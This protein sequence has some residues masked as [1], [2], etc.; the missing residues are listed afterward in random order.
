MYCI[1]AEYQ[2]IDYLKHVE[3]FSHKNYT[4][5][6]KFLYPSAKV[7]YIDNPKNRSLTHLQLQKRLVTS[8]SFDK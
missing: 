7:E 8:N 2:E 4:C 3:R 5:Q 1:L 6:V